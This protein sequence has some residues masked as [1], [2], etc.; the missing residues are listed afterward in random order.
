MVVLRPT[1]IISAVL[2]YYCQEPPASPL[3]NILEND[4]SKFTKSPRPGAGALGLGDS[5]DGKSPELVPG[6]SEPIVQIAA[7][8]QHTLA[9]SESG[10]VYATGSGEYGLLGQGD[11]ADSYEFDELE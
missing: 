2:G 1:T 8:Y 7:G 11:N 10:R 9:L 3:N 6:F 4:L 5:A